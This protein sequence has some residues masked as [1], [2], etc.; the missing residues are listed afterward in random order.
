MNKLN[1]H[2]KSIAGSVVIW[3]S[4]GTAAHVTDEETGNPRNCGSTGPGLEEA[5]T[6]DFGLR[7]ER[8][9]VLQGLIGETS[10]HSGGQGKVP[11]VR[12]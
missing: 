11:G 2:T 12:G 5:D 6:A 9:E 10:G 3:K 4:L 8:S 7:A 1:V